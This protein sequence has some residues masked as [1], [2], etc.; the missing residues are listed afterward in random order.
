MLCRRPLFLLLFAV[1]CVMCLIECIL[2]RLSCLINAFGKNRSMVSFAVSLN[3][4]GHSPNS[5]NHQVNSADNPLNLKHHRASS[6]DHSLSSM[7]DPLNSL[8]HSNG[9]KNNPHARWV[10][11]MERRM[12][13]QTLPIILWTWRMILPFQRTVA[14]FHAHTLLIRRSSR[15]NLRTPRLFQVSILLSCSIFHP[16]QSLLGRYNRH[17]KIQYNYIKKSMNWLL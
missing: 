7:H 12:T 13:R 6:L 16:K 15:F 8:R 5:K 17:V 3:S 14:S 10:I 1:K 11:Q 9:R 2:S 4:K